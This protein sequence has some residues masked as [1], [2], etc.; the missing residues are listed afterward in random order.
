MITSA[1]KGYWPFDHN[2]LAELRSFLKKLAE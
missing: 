1:Q 2:A